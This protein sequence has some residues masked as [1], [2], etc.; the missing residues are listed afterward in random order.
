M[1]GK[2]GEV[3]AHFEEQKEGS[4]RYTI[5]QIAV[6]RSDG[7][8]G[9]TPSPPSGTSTEAEKEGGSETVKHSAT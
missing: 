8:G 4:F 3:Y 9:A 7:A 1:D 5:K 2:S 6:S